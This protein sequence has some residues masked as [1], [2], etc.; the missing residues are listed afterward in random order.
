M[1]YYCSLLRY[2]HETPNTSDLEALSTVKCF[3]E[4]ERKKKMKGAV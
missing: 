4:K 1:N 2:L 3:I